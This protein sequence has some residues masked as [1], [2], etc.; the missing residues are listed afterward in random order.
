[1]GIAPETF[2]R[3]SL[4][5]WRAAL[6]GFMERNGARAAQPLERKALDDMMQLYPDKR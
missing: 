4:M 6:A 3:M 2:W 5:E 1:M